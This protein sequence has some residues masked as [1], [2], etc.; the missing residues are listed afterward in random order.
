MGIESSSYLVA[1]IEPRMGI[2]DGR[3]HFAGHNPK[4]SVGGHCLED[5]ASERESGVSGK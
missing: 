4:V 3:Y 1:V 5:V 2:P